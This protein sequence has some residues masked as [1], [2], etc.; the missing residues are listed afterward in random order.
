MNPFTESTWKRIDIVLVLLTLGV[1]LGAVWIWIIALPIPRETV[2][3][4]S[5]IALIIALVLVVNVAVLILLRL[6]HRVSSLEQIIA[7]TQREHSPSESE[8]IVV[9]LTKIER[10]VI[11]RLE[12]SDGTLTQ[13][14]LRRATGLSKSTL[15][16]TLKS[17][18]RKS[19]I[20]R[21]EAG[22]TKIVTLER[23]VPR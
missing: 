9:T 8:V 12:E 10:R 22:R 14:A 20:S 18:E 1:L 15:S 7:G 5:T 2:F 6:Q 16:V 11:N 13:D 21:I 3:L 17:L 23:S 4:A 19:L